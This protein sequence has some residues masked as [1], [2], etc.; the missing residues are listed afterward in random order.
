[1]QDTP[2]KLL[3]IPCFAW[4][5]RVFFSDHIRVVFM[6]F[7]SADQKIRLIEFRALKFSGWHEYGGD[8]GVEIDGIQR[9]QQHSFRRTCA[10][11]TQV[12]YLLMRRPFTFAD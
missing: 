2:R 5:N 8:V 9:L 1:T 3:N 10:T 11:D 4:L 12:Q 7:D 6:N